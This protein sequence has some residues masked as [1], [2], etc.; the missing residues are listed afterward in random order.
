MAEQDRR[1]G[2]L[3]EELQGAHPSDVLAVV[4]RYLQRTAGATEVRLLLADYS[5]LSMEQ[6]DDRG[7]LHVAE[8]VAIETSTPGRPT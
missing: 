4:S 5:E 1:P 3:L 7:E 2:D 6:L 8:P